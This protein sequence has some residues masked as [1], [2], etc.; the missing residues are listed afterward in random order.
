MTQNNKI[1]SDPITC[2]L[3]SRKLFWQMI[4]GK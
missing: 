1:I 2:Q 4:F 3:E